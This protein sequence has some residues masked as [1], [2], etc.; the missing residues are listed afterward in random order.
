MPACGTVPPPDTE[1]QL[2]RDTRVCALDSPQ[3]DGQMLHK[4]RPILQGSERPCAVHGN[5]E[6][7]ARL[8][9]QVQVLAA[10]QA[11]HPSQDLSWHAQV[12]ALPHSVAQEA[13]L[14]TLWPSQAHV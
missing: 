8:R 2:P 11:P 12:C 7:Q 13:M 3:A 5:D 14:Q 1:E 9:C 6:R 10:S 4:V